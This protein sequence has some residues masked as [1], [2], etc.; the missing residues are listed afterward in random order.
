MAAI[1]LCPVENERFINLIQRKH[2]ITCTY[3]KT[4]K[5]SLSD[6]K[7]PETFPLTRHKLQYISFWRKKRQ[8]KIKKMAP[9]P[10]FFMHAQHVQEEK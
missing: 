10:A 9:V 7:K 3:L 1:F 8:Q 4:R 2:M 6:E 5:K